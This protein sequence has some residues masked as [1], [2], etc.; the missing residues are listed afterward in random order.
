LA[1]PAPRCNGQRWRDGRRPA[2]GAAA[3][4]PPAQG[5]TAGAAI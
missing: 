2:P 4:S 1:A 5:I 3:S